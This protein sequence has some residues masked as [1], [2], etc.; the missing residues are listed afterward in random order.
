MTRLD[1]ESIPSEC[2]DTCCLFQDEVMRCDF[3]SVSHAHISTSL[4]YVF[5][6]YESQCLVDCVDGWMATGWY[7]LITTMLGLKPNA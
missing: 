6:Y 2:T 3:K 7:I 4:S 5:I 1:R